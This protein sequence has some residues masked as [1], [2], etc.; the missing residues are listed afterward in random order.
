MTPEDLFFDIQI[1]N[2]KEMFAPVTQL[3][4]VDPVGRTNQLPS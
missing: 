2:S 4:F 3:L 1:L